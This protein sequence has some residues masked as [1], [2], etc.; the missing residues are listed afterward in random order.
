MKELIPLTP[1]DPK[2]GMPGTGVHPQDDELEGGKLLPA[3][4]Q[5]LEGWKQQGYELVSMRQYLEGLDG[6]LPRCEVSMG[7]VKGRV[8]ELALQS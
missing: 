4:E 3:F 5:L 2:A 7:P 8:G 6:V 1:N